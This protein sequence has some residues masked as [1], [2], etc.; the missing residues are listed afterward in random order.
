MVWAFGFRV[1]GL[2]DLG[3]LARNALECRLIILA[4]AKKVT[5]GTSSELYKQRA[6]RLKL[7]CLWIAGRV[8]GVAWGLQSLEPCGEKWKKN[9][10]NSVK[11]RLV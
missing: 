10:D 1:F 9:I 6:G 7:Y 5:P 2:W 8:E 4:Q 3:L 11:S